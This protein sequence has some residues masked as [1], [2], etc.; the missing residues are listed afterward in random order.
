MAMK[1]LLPNALVI[2]VIMSFLLIVNS[3]IVT[4]AYSATPSAVPVSNI[5]F[6]LPEVEITSAIPYDHGLVLTLE[7]VNIS[8]ITSLQNSQSQLLVCFVNSSMKY[9]MYSSTVSSVSGIISTVLNGNLIVIVESSNSGNPQSIV[10]NF[11]GLHFEDYYTLNGIILTNEPPSYNLTYLSL[12][13]YSSNFR[14]ANYTLLFPNGKVTFKDELPVFAL[15]LPEGILVLAYNVTYLYT[16]NNPI[17]PYNLTL[18]SNNGQIIWTN[19]YYLSYYSPQILYGGITFSS[20]LINYAI[21]GNTLYI[22]NSTMLKSGNSFTIVNES[23]LGIS[24]SNGDLINS[25]QVSPNTVGL[26]T[27]QGTLYGIVFQHEGVTVTSPVKYVIVQKYES[28]NIY[29]VVKIPFKERTVLKNITAPNG[30]VTSFNYTQPLTNIFVS[31]GNFILVSSPETGSS[32]SNVTV[33]HGDNVYSYTL[34]FEVTQSLTP[35]SMILLGNSSDNYYLLFLNPNG[36]MKY[37]YNIGKISNANLLGIISL[38]GVKIAQVSPECYYVAYTSTYS[39]PSSLLPGTQVNID[40]ITFNSSLVSS[41]HPPTT[42]SN[43]NTSSPSPLSST[44]ILILVVIVIAVIV[45]LIYINKR[46]F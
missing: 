11:S 7:Y 40:L 44:L 25:F 5:Q 34:D 14:N 12:I 6:Q 8:S 21:L 20:T 23:L 35:N 26:G 18:L 28:G 17:I 32:G 2:L 29:P 43:S 41:V 1:G 42:T 33:I 4:T 39:N 37:Y 45:G 27:T 38:V 10:Y 15:Q 22:T 19:S 24:L 46:G 31:D 9:Q 30:K 36:S 16:S 3:V 13:Q